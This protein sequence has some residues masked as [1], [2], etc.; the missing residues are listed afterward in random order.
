MISKISLF[1]VFLWAANAA[2]PGP[3]KPTSRTALAI[4]RNAKTYSMT[5]NA[6]GF[7]DLIY[8]NEI[9]LDTT[10]IIRHILNMN[11]STVLILFPNRWGKTINLD[12]LRQFVELQTDVDGNPKNSSY[13]SVF[14]KGLIQNKDEKESYRCP[15][16]IA[17]CKALF[18][19]NQGQHPVIFVT[20][21]N[22]TGDNYD[23]MK[24]QMQLAIE[25]EYRRHKYVLTEL[26]LS[27]THAA[28]EKAERFSRALSQEAMNETELIS[29]IAFLSELLHHH[30]NKKVFIFLD[31]FDA[32]LFN[33]IKPK[34]YYTPHMEYLVNLTDHLLRSTFRKNPNVKKSIITG[35]CYLEPFNISNWPSYRLYD[36][37]DSPLPMVE[38]FGF[39]Q[40]E[41]DIIYETLNIGNYENQMVHEWYRIPG[42]SVQTF[43]NPS[44]IVRYLATREIRSYIDD[45]ITLD[46][47]AK[48]IT[49]SYTFRENVFSLLSRQAIQRGPRWVINDDNLIMFNRLMIATRIEDTYFRYTVK[50]YDILDI[51]PSI[52]TLAFSFLLERGFLVPAE[53]PAEVKIAKI[54]NHEIAYEFATRMIWYFQRVYKIDTK[55]LNDTS[56]ALLDYFKSELNYSASLQTSLTALYRGSFIKVVP[57]NETEAVGPHGPENPHYSIFSAI[58]LNVQRV[59]KFQVQAFYSRYFQSKLVLV[60]PV[61]KHG[62]II[63]LDYNNRSVED[64]LQQAQN[65]SYVFNK[66]FLNVKT[67]KFIGISISSLLQINITASTGENI[68]IKKVNQDDGVTFRPDIT[69]EGM[70]RDKDRVSL[71]FWDSI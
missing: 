28:E 46:F 31:D 68:R 19:E 52:I 56:L 58:S 5:I 36:S 29:S 26:Q 54:P 23:E 15:F 40:D 44:S 37:V 12:V 14:R 39:R 24:Y 48:M 20:F 41:M 67:V 35:T 45:T 1:W 71:D 25:R 6:T 53:T 62:A 65:Y 60:D 57:E 49:L 70:E 9:F 38:Y 42:I 18:P 11:N 13:S 27:P 16:R 50:R 55:L 33:F 63:Q 51:D 69:L 61:K 8:K 47:I 21:Q 3:D 32:P 4:K 22:V 34:Q 7:H 30:F 2:V 59:S 64:A 43:Y 10:S 17:R 66:W